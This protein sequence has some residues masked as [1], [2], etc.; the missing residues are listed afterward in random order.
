MIGGEE[1]IFIKYLFC[2]WCVFYIIV[3]V[4]YALV[5]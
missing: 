5:Y 3:G 2:V 1:I 4:V